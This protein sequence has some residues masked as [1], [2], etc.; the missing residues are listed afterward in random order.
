[1]RA[2]YTIMAIMVAL[3][4]RFGGHLLV[5]SIHATLAVKQSVRCGVLVSG[6][7]FCIP[8]SLVLPL[9]FL[10]RAGKLL[11]SKKTESGQGSDDAS[12][13]RA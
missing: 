9:L 3:L 5:L 7:W 8:S 6:V 12:I 2:F 13:L 1:M 4:L 10:H 11:C